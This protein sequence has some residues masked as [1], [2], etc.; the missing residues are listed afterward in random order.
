VDDCGWLW[1]NVGNFGK[2]AVG[3]FVI[4]MLDLGLMGALLVMGIG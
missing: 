2:V 4:V 3:V 1:T